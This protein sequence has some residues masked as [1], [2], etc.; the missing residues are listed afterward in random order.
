MFGVV[1]R[2]CLFPDKSAPAGCVVHSYAAFFYPGYSALMTATESRM[3]MCE[4]V[5]S[6]SWTP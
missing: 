4:L 5:N 1:K 6:F 3:N 2:G